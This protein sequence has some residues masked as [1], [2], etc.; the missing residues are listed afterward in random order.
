[1]SA[2]VSVAGLS[3]PTRP[4]APDLVEE[5][6]IPDS[7]VS[8]LALRYLWM[9]GSATLTALNDRLKLS[10]PILES[11]FHELRRQQLLEVKGMTGHDYRFTLSEAGRSRAAA[12]QEVCQYCGPVPVSLREYDRV[13]R[14]QSA[15][16]R[17]NREQLRGLF[18]DLVLPDGLLDQLGPS[19]IGH[20]S[21]FL[22]GETGGG[23]TSIAERLLRVY[24][25]AILVPYAIEVDGHI[26]TVFDPT[27]HKRLPATDDVLDP[28]WVECARPCI[29]VG[30]ELSAAMLELQM[31]R[32]TRVFT[33]PCQLKANNGLLIIDD[34]G[35]QMI[36][37]RELLNRWIVPLDRRVDYLTLASGM[38]F[39]IP[40]ELMVV[41]S[42]KPEPLRPGG[43]GVSAAHSE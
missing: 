42:T 18:S 8:D 30:G 16:I 9:H 19:L 11:L 38:K 28:R 26:V 6:G 24:R 23:K 34:F 40:F 43:R 17:L 39:E 5:L 13:V 41:F 37:P 31:D 33:S 25:D 12:R 22:Y 15:R 14:S 3:H 2:T 36:S 21:L 27:V 35:R 20:R 4:Q 29:T 10:F 1:M 7:L 32:A